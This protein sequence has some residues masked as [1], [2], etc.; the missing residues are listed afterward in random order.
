M[1]IDDTAGGPCHVD[2]GG[3]DRD[4][5]ERGGEEVELDHRL[6]VHFARRKLALPAEHERHGE[7]DVDVGRREEAGEA[8]RLL[9]VSRGAAFG[10]L[11]NDGDT[12]VLVTNNNGPVRLF[13][14]RIGKRNHWLGLRLL[15]KSANRDMLGAKVQIIVTPRQVLYRRV[16]TD[17]SYCSSQDPRVLV[18][19]GSAERIEAIRVR[20]PDESVDEWKNPPLNRYLTL[21]QGTSSEKK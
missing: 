3:P 21:K 13:L 15:G 9:E 4:Q 17:G 14:N 7:I 18:G 10:D 16:R 12:D 2:R 8:F 20:W 1:T 19:I 11:D 5:R 6:I